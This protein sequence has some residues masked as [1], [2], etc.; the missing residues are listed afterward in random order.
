MEVTVTNLDAEGSTSN[1]ES[2]VHEKGHL[3]KILD[4]NSPVSVLIEAPAGSGMAEGVI[5]ANL[6]A[7]PDPGE[8]NTAIPMNKGQVS[9][10]DKLGPLVVQVLF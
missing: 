5:E 2:L 10:L 8:G 1:F 3:P 4:P 7:L 9:L 6:L